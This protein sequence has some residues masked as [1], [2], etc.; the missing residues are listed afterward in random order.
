MTK[1]KK[2]KKSSQAKT[3]EKH[4][5][6]FPDILAK[7][8][9]KVDMRAQ[10]QASMLSQFLLIIGLTIM[11]LFMIISNQTTGLYKF[12]VIFNLLCGWVLISSYLITT[13]QQYTHFSTQMG[14]DPAAE[15]AAV[16]KKG[17]IFKRIKIAIKNKHAKKMKDK[18]LPEEAV[19]G[20]ISSLEDVKE[21]KYETVKN[22]EE[23]EMKDIPLEKEMKD[24]PASTEMKD[25]PINT[26]VKGGINKDG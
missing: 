1:E 3:K 15:K 8:M 2:P 14:F 13:Y 23:K 12:I 24:I 5:Y 17:H 4:R 6:V 20:L 11:V 22:Y 9:S 16:K 10:M 21:G 19:K 7:A 26:E 18:E 25:I